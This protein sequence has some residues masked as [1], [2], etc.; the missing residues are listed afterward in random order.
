MRV[1][2]VMTEDVRTISP[3]STAEQ[4]WN[5][6]RAHRIHHLVVTDGPQIVGLV[7]D[8]VIGG[9]REAAVR[10]IRVVAD[11]MTTPAVTVEPGATLREVANLMRGRSIG[12]VVVTEGGRAIGILTVSDL[13]ELIGRGLDR[14]TA[15]TKR[16]TLKHRAPHRKAKQPRHAW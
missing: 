6:M 2:D 5:L 11:L 4:A 12:C 8:R 13:L 3:S 1:Q 7:S 14:G 10:K 16:W 9:A 15:R